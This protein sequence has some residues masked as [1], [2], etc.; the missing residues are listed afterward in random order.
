MATA[1]AFREGMA[2][3]WLELPTSPA[4]PPPANP[5]ESG[6]EPNLSMNM[7]KPET[8][9]GPEPVAHIRRGVLNFQQISAGRVS[10]RPSLSAWSPVLRWR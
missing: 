10:S 6:R 1:L 3:E 5:D 2:G 9:S 7:K 4:R 8:Q